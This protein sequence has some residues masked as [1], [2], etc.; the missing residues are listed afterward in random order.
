MRKGLTVV[1]CCE[2]DC[3]NKIGF[4]TSTTPPEIYCNDC[5]GMHQLVH[6]SLF[7]LDLSMEDVRMNHHIADHWPKNREMRLKN[8]LVV[9]KFIQIAKALRGLTWNL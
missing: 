9:I 2:P 8:Q 4:T 3:G 6:E 5:G 7:R 1:V